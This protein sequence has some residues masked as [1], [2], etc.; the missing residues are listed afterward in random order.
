MT[1][2]DRKD[3]KLLRAIH[4]AY[5]RLYLDHWTVSDR[6]DTKLLRAI[7][8]GVS[9]RENPNETVS[10][11]KDTKLLRAIHN[12]NVTTATPSI[13]FQTAKIQNF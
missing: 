1:V 4:N 8:N 7:H 2:S 9:G 12:L 13:L 10:D 6:K 11:R 3:T 5:L